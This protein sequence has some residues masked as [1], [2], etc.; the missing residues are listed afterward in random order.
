[1]LKFLS[2]LLLYEH[3]KKKVYILVDEYDKPVNYF[4]EH[5][6]DYK[7]DERRE[8]AE[9]ITG[10]MSACGKSNPYLEKIV[11]TGIFDIFTKEGG[12]GFNNLSVHDISDDIFGGDLVFL[13]KR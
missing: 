1:M 12:S 7:P 9:L 8:V 13:R 2:E 11:L 10:I 5:G 3:H 6:L 4:V